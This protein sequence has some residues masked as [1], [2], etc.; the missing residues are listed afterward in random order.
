MKVIM[1]ERS[2]DWYWSEA[3][4]FYSTIEVA[5]RFARNGGLVKKDAGEEEE[6]K[7]EP[8]FTRES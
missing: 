2:W 6:D 3:G 7:E 8:V 5:N 1:R 4:C